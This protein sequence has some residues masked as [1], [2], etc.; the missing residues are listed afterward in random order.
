MLDLKVTSV[1]TKEICYNLRC[2]CDFQR[3][4]YELFIQ[5][6][7]MYKRYGQTTHVIKCKFEI[8]LLNC[9]DIGIPDLWNDLRLQIFFEAL[10]LNSLLIDPNISSSIVALI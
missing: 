8:K 7:K 4:I 3:S 2:S 9:L 6:I 10:T 1:S 5:F